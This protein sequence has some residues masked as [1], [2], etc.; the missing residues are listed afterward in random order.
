MEETPGPAVEKG[1]TSSERKVYYSLE[2]NMDAGTRSNLI[3]AHPS[4][5]S[6]K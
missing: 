5:L 4:V 1:K 2:V 3:T 6:H